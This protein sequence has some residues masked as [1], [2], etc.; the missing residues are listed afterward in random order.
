MGQ[1][2]TLY[3][4][5]SINTPR[6]QYRVVYD[7]TPGRLTVDFTGR[8]FDSKNFAGISGLGGAMRSTAECESCYYAPPL[9]GGGIKHYI[10]PRPMLLSDVCLSRTSA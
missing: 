2:Y 1:H 8:S 10:T 7:S 3:F 5:G 6:H 9:I 4:A